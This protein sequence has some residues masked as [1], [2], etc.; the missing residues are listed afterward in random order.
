[1]FSEEEK[2]VFRAKEENKETKGAQEVHENNETKVSYPID[3]VA[4]EEVQ[5]SLIV[6]SDLAPGWECERETAKNGESCAVLSE[7]QAMFF[8]AASSTELQLLIVRHGS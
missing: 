6:Q 2:G 7:G 3:Q 8:L 4:A 1:M 5:V